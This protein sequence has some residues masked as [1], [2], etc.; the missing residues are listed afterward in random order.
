MN[1]S[2]KSNFILLVV[3][4]FLCGFTSAAH[5]Q[6]PRIKG[7]TVL[8]TGNVKKALPN[9]PVRLRGDVLVGNGRETVSD[10]EG[11]Y[12][13]SDLI[14]GDYTVSVELQGIESYERR[15]PVQL[16]STLDL[17]IELKPR[18][19]SESVTVTDTTA[20][21]EAN[22]TA[23]VP[24]VVTNETLTN[25][26]L[27]DERFQDALPLIPGVVRTGEGQL[28]IKG[29]RENQS[30]TL[31]SSLNVTD[32]VTG[33]SAIEI[34]LDAVDTI[35]VYSNPYSA[36]YG[37]FT[38]AIVQIETR[39]GT[40]EFKFVGSN[41]LPRFR[42]IDGATVGIERFTP[43][44]GFQVPSSKT[45]SSFS[46]ASSTASYARRTTACAKCAG[47]APTHDR[48]PSI[49]SRDLIMRSTRAIV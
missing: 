39:A 7:R 3:V 33:A 23:S 34:P 26:P 46:K 32:P 9:V 40:N 1:R 37:R 25:A 12:V 29:A 41:I 42:N 43:R 6:T 18:D 30:G 27:I 22:D 20:P 21:D 10:E 38:G 16:G 47:F 36:E 35:Q 28:S 2:I 15:V 11:N 24:S 4:L 45:N 19:V 13:F 17:N 14:A 8:I 31:V 49:H 48:K 5:A 44:I